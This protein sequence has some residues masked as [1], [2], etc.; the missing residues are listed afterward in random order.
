MA[1]GSTNYDDSGPGSDCGHVATQS[2]WHH[3]DVPTIEGCH[4]A[5]DKLNPHVRSR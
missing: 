5:T 2:S 4:S 1:F 3:W